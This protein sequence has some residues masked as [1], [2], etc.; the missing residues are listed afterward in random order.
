[1]SFD[2]KTFKELTAPG[3]FD[4]SAQQTPK[5]AA[6]AAWFDAVTLDQQ[7][8]VNLIDETFRLWASRDYTGVTSSHILYLYYLS[9]QIGFSWLQTDLNVQ[10]EL[11]SYLSSPRPDSF[12]ACINQLYNLL[13]DIEWISGTGRVIA[14]RGNPINF[15][16]TLIIF[17]ASVSLPPTPPSTPYARRAW[18]APDDWTR[19]PASSLWMTRGYM[20]GG[21]IVWL[22]PV[23]T[24]ALITYYDSADLAGLPVS[25]ND[26]DI[27]GVLDDGS[28]DSGAIYAYSGAAWYKCSTLYNLQGNVFDN[29]YLDSSGIFAPDVDP[30]VTAQTPPPTDGPSLGYGFYGLYGINPTT[31]NL[32]IVITL[33]DAGDAN[34]GTIIQLFRRIKPAVAI[35]VF[36]YVTYGLTVSTIPIKD[37]NA[38]N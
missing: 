14:G 26:G 2:R 35:R 16:E 21:E 13:F 3:Y 36:L 18:P 12:S 19:A 4:F 1:M 9:Q 38:I 22:P 11:V 27:G 10:R 8:Q 17:S 25:A 20:S 15:A 6:M 32:E 24:S 23:S 37:L 30:P 33:T 7:N 31:E 29:T 28:G 34:I 5:T